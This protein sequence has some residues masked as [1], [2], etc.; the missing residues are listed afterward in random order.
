MPELPEVE[1]VMRQVKAQVLHMKFWKV[2]ISD[3]ALVFPSA[4]VLEDLLPGKIIEKVRRKGKFL[5]FDLSENLVMVVHLRMTGMLLFEPSERLKKFI[6][7]EFIFSNARKMFFSDIRRF[8]R[9]WLYHKS[10]YLRETGLSKLGLD[11]ILEDL[12]L[13]LLESIYLNRKGVLKNKLLDQTLVAG[14]GN[15]YADEICFRTGLHPASRTEKLNKKD[16]AALQEAIIHCLTEGI[17]HNGTTVS[18]FV[19]TRGD[20]GKH[21]NY[22]Q[23]YGRTGDLCYKCGTVIKKT[24]VAGRGTYVCLKCQKLRR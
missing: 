23:I 11:P 14:I 17:K 19:G 20:A 21:Q 24:R 6:R 10:E 1:T 13:K 15:I 8:G 9:I 7:V 4:A 12:D 16:L 2:K 22:L 3:K 18:D 5:I